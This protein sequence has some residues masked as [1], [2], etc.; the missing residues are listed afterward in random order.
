MTQ[1]RKMESALHWFIVCI[2]LTSMAVRAS[3][4]QAPCPVANDSMFS[5]ISELSQLVSFY[6]GVH[7]NLSAYIVHTKIIEIIPKAI[8]PEL[9]ANAIQVPKR[10]T[11]LEMP[12]FPAVDGFPKLPCFLLP[13]PIILQCPVRSNGFYFS[14]AS[15]NL[16]TTYFPLCVTMSVHC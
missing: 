14:G 6:V 5:L 16:S 4:R 12:N 3:S 7:K 2:G 1:P 13:H 8:C 11:P 9:H 15:G 10:Q